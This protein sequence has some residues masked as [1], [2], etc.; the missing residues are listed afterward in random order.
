[1]GYEKR[2]ALTGCDDL[3]AGVEER[4]VLVEDE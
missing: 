4:R 3:V 1:M 2:L